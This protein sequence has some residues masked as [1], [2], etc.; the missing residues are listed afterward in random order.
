MELAKWTFSDIECW[1]I[2][3]KQ[4]S[5]QHPSPAMG[6]T[7]ADLL[8]Y[9]KEENADGLAQLFAEEKK[10]RLIMLKKR[11]AADL[12]KVPEYWIKVDVQRS[13]SFESPLPA[14]SPNHDKVNI[15]PGTVH[16]PITSRSLSSNG[17]APCTPSSSSSASGTD[18]PGS[19]G[20]CE[21]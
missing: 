13:L 17:A 20:S 6:L 12:D 1:L 15:G 9:M 3:T 5:D 21:T 8:D 10:H 14:A 2:H 11:V 18:E 4:H 16:S 19:V 7:G